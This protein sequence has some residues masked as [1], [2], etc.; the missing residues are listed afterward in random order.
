M[1]TIDTTLETFLSSNTQDFIEVVMFF[2]SPFVPI[3]TFLSSNTQ[4]FIEVP[5]E[6]REITRAATFL[7]SNTQDFIEVTTQ[8]SNAS[9]AAPI[10]EL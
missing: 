1:R 5:P 4:D 9:S 8:N 7:S 6:M 3:C 2:V 10:P